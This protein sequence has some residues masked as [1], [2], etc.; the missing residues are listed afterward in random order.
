MGICVAQILTATGQKVLIVLVMELFSCIKHG[1]KHFMSAMDM[2][3]TQ[4]TLVQAS[5]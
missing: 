4:S 1:T 5:S 2:W 3:P